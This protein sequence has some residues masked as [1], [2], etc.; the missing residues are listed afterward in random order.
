MQQ[1]CQGS[2][3]GLA[4]RWAF[5]DGFTLGNSPGV[6]QTTFIAA[7]AALGLRRQLVDGVD[8]MLLT[9]VLS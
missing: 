1:L 5:V 7:A 9:A 2:D 4:S 3:G 8:Q 6:G